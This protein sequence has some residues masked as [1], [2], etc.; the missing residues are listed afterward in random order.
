MNIL[1]SEWHEKHLS[2]ILNILSVVDSI[3]KKSLKKLMF[4]FEN[5][6]FVLHYLKRKSFLIEGR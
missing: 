1:S 6:I 2:F 4:V 5:K 3:H